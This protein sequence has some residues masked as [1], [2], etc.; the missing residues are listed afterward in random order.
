MR[1]LGTSPTE[2]FSFLGWVRGVRSAWIQKQPGRR[3]WIF[4]T[5]A[6][7]FDLGLSIYFFLFN[8]F[9]LEHGF[10]EKRMGFITSALTIG[11]VVGA[12]PIGIL[13]KRW[14]LRPLLLVCFVGVPILCVL[15]TFFFGI[16]AQIVL[17]FFAGFILCINAVCLPPAIARLTT[18]ENRSFGFSVVFATGIGAGSLAGILGGSLPALLKNVALF[19]HAAD[20]MR[21]V[22]LLSCAVTLLAALPM[23]GLRLESEQK[24]ERK[25]RLFTPFL[26]RF[27]PAIA[28][29]SVVTGFFAPFANVYFA[30]HM[31][32]PLAQ[33]GL[34]FSLSQLVQVGAVLLAPVLYRA[35]GTIPGVVITQVATGV[36]LLMLSHAKTITAA[37]VFYLILTGVQWMS[38]PGIYSMVMDRTPDEQRSNAAAMQNVVTASSQAAA[39]ATAGSLFD[40]HGYSKP[41]AGGAGVAALAA[42][43]LYVLLG[44]DTRRFATE[45]VWPEHDRDTTMKAEGLAAKSSMEAVQPYNSL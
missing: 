31:H 8:L 25:A 29:W 20:G 44:K 42:M 4:F 3:F 40:R 45:Q 17:A 23:R 16:S 43:L 26:L 2:G 7:F 6:F 1:L 18:P 33:I 9:L 22:L 10:T 11:S 37:R 38:G 14:G 19:G 30:R 27:L 13:A 32:M 39:A 34:V 21:I 5:A 41:L 35:V 28:V 15:R 36:S 24:E 12:L